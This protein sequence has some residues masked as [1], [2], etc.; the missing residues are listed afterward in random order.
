[1]D[2]G[3][4]AHLLRRHVLAD[5]L[6]A[7]PADHL[8]ADLHD[9]SGSIERFPHALGVVGAERHRLFLIDVLTGLD[10]GHEV[11]GV[12]MLRRRD[13]HGVYVLVV[14]QLPEVLVGLDRRGERLHFVQPA[15][16]QVGCGDGLR[17]AA[18][19]GGLEYLL[20]AAAAPDEPEPD[21]IICA[22]DPAGRDQARHGDSHGALGALLHERAAVRHLLS[23]HWNDSGPKRNRKPGRE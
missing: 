11:E 19:H 2:G 5:H 9:A 4:H 20:A 6:D 14:E 3:N 16:V 22:D 23:P 13:E 15:A 7:G 12:L 8:D 21:P 18:A 1:M 10:G 17:V